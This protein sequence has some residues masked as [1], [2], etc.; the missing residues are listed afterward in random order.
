MIELV[1]DARR[2]SLGGFDVG[3]VLPFHKRRMVGPFVFF[4]HMG[5]VDFPAGVSRDIDVRPHPHIGLST[6]TYLFA[7]EIMH[8]DS[9][10]SVQPI[11]P[12]EVNWMT[13]GSGVTHSERFERAQRAG[14]HVDGIQ[15]WVA[16]P[17]EFE[18]TAPSF[19][20]IEASGLP[21]L[22]EGD[23]DGRLIAGEAFGA[24]AEVPVHSPLFY[25]HWTLPVGARLALPTD[26]P[27]RAVYVASG[28][29]EAG[30]TRLGPGQ[31]AVFRPGAAPVLEALAPTVLLALGGE[32][33]GP[34]FI[35]WNFVSSR[36]ERIEQAKADWRA[37]RMK[38]PDHD[39]DEFIPLPPEP[40]APANPMS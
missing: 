13:A 3:R 28:A 36:K 18:E 26:Y 10:G 29:I 5:P 9:V 19:V 12:G 25:I 30:S 22:A 37:G 27:E 34:R 2:R 20:H 39:S 7:G 11:A 6:L 16:L 38:L 40:G 32:P 33:I 23:V 24:R 31:M 1:I 21:D 4:D 15:A 35:D 14:D 17:E 8:R